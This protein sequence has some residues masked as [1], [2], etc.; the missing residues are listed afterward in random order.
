LVSSGAEPDLL[1]RIPVTWIWFTGD[2]CGYGIGL[3]KESIFRIE[4]EAFAVT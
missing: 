3:K 2:E 4:P 1:E